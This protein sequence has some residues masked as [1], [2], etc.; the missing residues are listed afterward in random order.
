MVL[1]FDPKLMLVARQARGLSQAD[2]A[3]MLGINQG[4]LSKVENGLKEPSKDVIK[5]IAE[6]LGFPESF[7]FQREEIYGLPVSVHPLHRK[8]SSVGIRDLEVIHA[9]LNIRIMNLKRLLQSVELCPKLPMPHLDLEDYNEDIEKIAELVRNT[10]LLP[11]GPIE[12]LT[13]SLERAGCLVVWCDFS[14]IAIDGVTLSIYKMPTIIFLNRH[15]PSDR[16]RFTL[17][18]ELGHIIMHRIP[19]PNMETQADAFASALLMPYHD[20]KE[21]FALLGNRLTLEHLAYLK[22]IWRVSIQSLLMRGKDIRVINKNQSDYL[23]KQINYRRMRFQEPPELNFP[24]E[25]PRM[26]PTI[27]KLHFDDLGYSISDLAKALHLYESELCK[28]YYINRNPSR[29]R[30][31][32]VLS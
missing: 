29:G 27:L 9:E 10:W 1:S 26:L 7:F 19:N 28:K 11:R 32:R 6:A 8:K 15:R 21:S 25:E 24:P 31:L 20:I 23:W 22:P 14:N 17:A 13:E 3:E 16:M 30:H 5:R 2:L 12:N 4:F 18:H